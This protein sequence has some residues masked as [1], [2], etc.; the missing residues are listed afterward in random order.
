[1]IVRNEARCLARCLRSA[2]TFVDD[3]IIC[4]T[5]STDNTVDIAKQFGAKVIHLP[6]SGDFANARNHC[7]NH[8]HADWN[9]V[10]DA[11][12][13]ID[14]AVNAKT[15]RLFTEGTHPKV[16][17]VCVR[18]T[19]IMNGRA[20]Y[21]E[22]WLPRLLPREIRYVGRIHEQPD[23]DLPHRRTEVLLHHDGY[24]PE[25]ARAK[26]RR[27]FDLLNAALTS[28]P[29]NPALHYQLGVQHDA[30]S[31]WEEACK[32]YRQ[33]LSLGATDYPFAHSLGVRLLHA[34]CRTEQYP[35]ALAWGRRIENLW[36]N[37]SDVYFAIG[38]MCL[39][40]ANAEPE[41]AIDSWLPSAEAGWKRCIEI[42]EDTAELDEHVVG[43]GSFLAA[44]NLRIVHDALE[45]LSHQVLA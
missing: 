24:E 37:S 21:A 32:S 19:F 39:D 2:R 20:E 15:L 36:P 6:W 13:W 26:A 35:E 41:C 42:G 17:L 22:S 3:I 10:L 44:H 16:G 27:N 28:D 29:L 30:A 33:A 7:L 38:N 12:E 1:M 8:S 43:R 11:D 5:G 14:S 18:S 23:H 40:L 31:D 9:L 34:L 4:D 45:Q 25:R